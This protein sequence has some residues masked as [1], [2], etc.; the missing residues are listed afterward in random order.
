MLLL[1]DVLDCLL[2][3]VGC[4]RAWSE[5]LL[6]DDEDELGLLSGLTIGSTAVVGV[7]EGSRAA[8]FDELTLSRGTFLEGNVSAKSVNG[9]IVR[10]WLRFTYATISAKLSLQ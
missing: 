2:T 3:G 5:S 10:Y 6:D 9:R 4:S 7:T 8:L 1:D